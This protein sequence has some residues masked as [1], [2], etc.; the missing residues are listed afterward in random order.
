MSSYIAL[1]RKDA[2]SDF[3]VDFPDFPG[4]VSA[5]ETLD[6]A[7]RMAREALELHVS[8]ILDEGEKL[9]APRSLHE[10]MADPENSDAVALCGSSRLKRRAV[11]RRCR[12]KT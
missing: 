1:I 5:G 7:R 8:G 4:C 10:I 2:H 3:G 9:P 6:E 12:Q 11:Q